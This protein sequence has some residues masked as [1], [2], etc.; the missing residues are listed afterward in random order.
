MTPETYQD[1]KEELATLVLNTS[2]GIQE[3]AESNE[4]DYEDG[5][6][7]RDSEDEAETG[8]DDEDSVG[9]GAPAKAAEEK[10]LPAELVLRV[11]ESLHRKLVA[12][13]KLE[14]VLVEDFV[15]ELLA[16]GLVLRA[17]E[18][19]ERKNHVRDGGQPQRQGF[20]QQNQGSNRGGGGQNQGRG[21]NSFRDNRGN[22]SGNASGNSGSGGA[23]RNGFRR[24]GMTQ[25]RY[26]TI[27]EDK[28]EFLEYVRAQERKNTR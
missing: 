15:S 24:S 17:W 2:S 8:S 6:G 25:N 9:N 10:K 1:N 13:A 20:S 11:S 21:G 14:G 5:P 12:K 7:R 18:I 23:G 28:A 4:D 19:M 22:G 16:E 3:P 26:N 27:M